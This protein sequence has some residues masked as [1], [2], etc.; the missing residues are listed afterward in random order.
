MANPA[1]NKKVKAFLDS[2]LKGSDK[3][4][5]EYQHAIMLIL[6]GALTDANFHSEAQQVDKYFPKAKKSKYVGTDMEGVIEDKGIAISKA[7][8]WDGY[9]IIDAFVA[10][11]KNNKLDSLKE[12]FYSEFVSEF[13]KE[14]THS[15]EYED[16]SQMGEDEND[17]QEI[18]V[19]NYQTKYFH[20]CP[21]ASNL[22]KDIESKGVD[23]GM[24]ERS[25]RLQDALFFVEE[26]IQRDGYKPERD[27][28]M[29]A[30]N[31][32]KNIMKLA[33]MMGLEKEHDYI[34]GH[35]DTIK[36]VVGDRITELT[37]ENVPTD[38][39]KWSY[40]KSQAK[41]KFDVYPSAY[42]NAWAAKQ[43]K[44]AGGGWR[45]KKSEATSAEEDE[46]HTKL[47]KLVHKT[48]GKSSDEK[49]ESVSEGMVA[50][51]R[52]HNY[53]QLIKNAPVKYIES[54]SNPTGATGVLLHN[55]DGYIKGVRGAY[56]ID[57]FGAHF[58][59]DL[60][61]KFATSIYGLKD[62]R[63]L[64]N[65]IQPVGMAP[66]HSD[67][68][69]YMREIPFRN[70][71]TLN[72]GLDLVE[73]IIFM[74]IIAMNLYD[75]SITKPIIKFFKSR[76]EIK[77]LVKKLAKNK[78]LV[79]AAKGK[80]EAEF[81]RMLT[82]TLSADEFSTLIKT[83]ANYD[84][85]KRGI[86]RE[87]MTEG[88]MSE[89]DLMAKEAK[90]FNDFL[91]DVFSVPAYRKHKGKKDVMD[92]LSKFYKDV[93]N[94]S[95]NEGRYGTYDNKE[96]KI[97]DKALDAAFKKFETALRKAHG[98]FQK[99]VKQYTY[100]GSKSDIGSKSGFQD[101]EGRGAIDYF[102][103]K[104]I[105]NELGIDKFGRYRTGWMDESVIKE[106][107]EPEIISQLKNIVAKK[108]NQ[109]LK[110]PKSGKMMRV[111]L[112]SA[113]AVTQVYDAL[114]QQKNKDKFVGLGL[115]GM[116]NMA[117]KL[118]KKESVNEAYVVMYA[119]NKGE[120]PAAAAYRDKDMALKFE[121]DLKKDGYITMVTQKKVK[122]VDESITEAK[123]KVGKETLNFSVSPMGQ[124]KN[125]LVFILSSAADLDKRD[126]AGITDRE[127]QT[128]I[129][130]SLNKNFK[131]KVDF[132]IDNGYNGA[133]YAFKVD[134]YQLA[135]TAD[136]VV[137]TKL[138]EEYYKSASEAADAARAY[139]EKKG[140]TI[141]EDDWQ[142]QIAMGGKHN[143][144]RPGKE[145]THK[146]SIGL[147]KN[148]KPQKK[149]LHISLYGMPSG[150]YELTQYIN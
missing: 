115:V 148:G 132:I 62:Q 102:A 94:E 142:T 89:L 17:P 144:L 35:I 84:K 2:Y 111:D 46:F 104:L 101:S 93:R 23:M 149:M 128:A 8:K 119:K 125:G 19:G 80:D 54:Q 59:V 76:K 31:I 81:Y 121:K 58:Y 135:R 86:A 124:D 116:V 57:Y 83:G 40:Y 91:K 9:E 48:F 63:E 27:Y 3:N 66:E 39:S 29:V 79:A 107:T 22:Y 25:V 75:G 138:N 14:V 61:S 71:S 38:P 28:V 64:R 37:E 16:M 145:K 36:K 133:G 43:Y 97:V 65:A 98:D 47:D 131:K 42:A 10:Y 13:L 103:Q 21:G 129:A 134:N 6:K 141:D 68:K 34:Q 67:W 11:T 18:K 130:K 110:D 70:E 96:A 90:D 77:A 4:S 88:V 99:A 26:H 136:F 30:N 122:G 106:G 139:A 105:Q 49:N 143:R 126:E 120:K 45:T 41:K 50:P 95:V 74:M 92:F 150:K 117:F 109:K 72:E 44:D 127:I 15:H 100:K 33:E 12:S 140:Y 147:S 123:V 73:Q 146:F 32:A 87:N 112:Y 82:D 24:A 51:R 1:L 20:V 55:K 7:A 85:V 53:Y 56:I 69:K 5:A 108:Q 60:K 78:E 114:K 52:G 137:E 118:L 113:S